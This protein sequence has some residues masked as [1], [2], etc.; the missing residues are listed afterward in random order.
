M[1]TASL[2][3]PV[4][5]YMAVIFRLSGQPVLPGV[6]L[7]PEWLSH[8][9]LHHGMAYGGLALLSLRAVAGGRWEAV[10]LPALLAAWL[11]SV[12]YGVSDEWH[13]SFVPG[14]SPEAR[15]VLVDGIGAALALAGARA[16]S[17]IRRA[18]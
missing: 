8:D 16:W 3:L 4:A 15:D 13:Q 14:R 5:V 12:A 7:L 17:I 18:S 6:S 10:R 9:W 11:I 1:R 2:W